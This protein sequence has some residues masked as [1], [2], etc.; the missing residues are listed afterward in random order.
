MGAMTMEFTV[1][2]AEM[3]SGIQVGDRVS[4]EFSGPLDIQ[5]IAVTDTN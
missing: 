2:Q 1:A 3:L 4:F 5:S